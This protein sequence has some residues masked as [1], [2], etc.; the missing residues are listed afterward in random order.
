MSEFKNYPFF[1][2]AQMRTILLQ[3]TR[4]F[5]GFRIQTGQ[6]DKGQQ[7]FISVACIYGDGSRQGWHMIRGG[8]ENTIQ[9]VPRIAVTITGLTPAALKRGRYQGITQTLSVT[10]RAY[11]EDTQSYTDGPGDRYQVVTLAPNPVDI[12]FKVDVWTSNTEQKFQLFEQI[13]LLF[14]PSLD[15]Q[16]SGNP[17]D[18]TALNII[19]LNDI[20]WDD[21]G[22]D[23]GTSD[24]I[25]VL[26]LTFTA[27][28]WINSPA[29]VTKQNLIQ[30]VIERLS[31]TIPDPEEGPQWQVV[32]PGDFNV[33]VNGTQITLL[34]QGGNVLDQNGNPYSWPQ[35]IDEYGELT[36]NQS[37]IALRW[38]TD[39]TNSSLDI[40]GLISLNETYDNILDFAIINETLPIPTLVGVI[41]VINPY[42][43]SPGDG[44]TSPLAGDR[45]IITEA[46]GHAA[47]STVAW[48]SLIAG[49]GDIIEYDGSSWND[50]FD[51]SSSITLQFVN[52]SESNL[53]LRLEVGQTNWTDFVNT[54]FT[55]G[56]WNFML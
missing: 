8:S 6:N 20:L 11:D 39:I 23:R 17:L 35:L 4:I 49:A 52:V 28:C 3:F 13:F 53:L 33:S 41:N 38:V 19:T 14:N 50:V 44:I 36:A 54:I 46:I 55:N 5:S 48:G 37:K 34:G 16:T 40:M 7:E 22:V 1:Y 21:Q 26:G 45:Y 15:F 24:N 27:Q 32:T 12:E 9:S 56:Y 18:W 10:E 51:A 42:V 2:S 31:G 43:T 25:N 30:T 29:Q 47:D